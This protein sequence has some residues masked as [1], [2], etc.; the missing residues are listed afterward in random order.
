MH[1]LADGMAVGLG[2][3]TT[4]SIF[5][6][7]LGSAVREGLFTNLFCVSTSTTS[8][9][10]ARSEG[11]A[12]TTLAE[13]ARQRGDPLLDIAVDG[14]DEVDPQLNLI[15]GLGRALLR[16]KFVE[17][18]TRQFIVLVSED[19]LVGRLGSRGPLPVELIQFEAE[20]SIQ[21]LNGLGCKAELWLEADGTPIVTD[22][23]NYLARCWFPDGIPDPAALA[24]TLAERPGIVEHGLFLGMA[25]RVITAGVGGVQTLIR[26]SFACR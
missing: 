2:S 26:S 19:K 1:Y 14:A 16:E 6:Q 25:E 18:H 15:K 20:R 5:I 12:L 21:W 8:A 4:S 3:G 13:L 22:N 11:I 17:I 9:E 7:L 23:G 10:L 24:N